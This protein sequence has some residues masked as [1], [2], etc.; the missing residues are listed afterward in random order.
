MRFKIHRSGL[1][2]HIQGQPR[3]GLAHYGISPSGPADIIAY[4]HGNYLVH[5]KMN[6][7]SL[8]ITL[9]GPHIEFLDAG[10]IAITGS[11]FL[12]KIN[13]RDI[14]YNRPIKIEKGQMLDIGS[15]IDGARCYLSIA[16]GI[17]VEDF[18][19]SK[20]THLETGVGGLNGRALKKNDIVN[21]MPNTIRNDIKKNKVKYDLNRTKILINKG[22]QH[23]LFSKDDWRIFLNNEYTVSSKSNRMGIRLEGGNKLNKVNDI[24]TEG[25]PLGAIQV[26]PNGFPIISFVEHQTTGGYP[27]IANVIAYDIPKLGQ[28]MPGDKFN[29]EL[30]DFEQAIKLKN[31]MN[32]LLNKLHD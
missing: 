9:L 30:I 8:E 16:G 20:S 31:E 1:Q 21:C 4:H 14:L 29:F 26:P 3:D 12:T 19:S 13:N 23:N 5:N 15:A 24:I 10:Y 17:D 25:I 28:L 2:T 11:K 32:I 27:K 7:A 22:L 6:A 18:L